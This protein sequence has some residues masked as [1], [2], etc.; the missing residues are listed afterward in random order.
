MTKL[1]G[2]VKLDETFC[3]ESRAYGSTQLEPV[4][5]HMARADIGAGLCT[6]PR[7]CMAN[8]ST[9]PLL[10]Y[11]P[12]GGLGNVL[13]GLASSTLLATV[14]CRRLGIAWGHNT[15]VQALGSF[16]EL[17]QVPAG[18]EFLNETEGKA[19]IVALDGGKVTSNCTAHMGKTW[20]EGGSR[21]ASLMHPREFTFAGPGGERISAWQCPVL[22]VRSNM[23]FAPALLKNVA[24]NPAAQWLRTHGLACT[25]T[26]TAVSA[27][28][29]HEPSHQR[30]KHDT[31]NA[32]VVPYFGE[33]SYHL[34]V[35]RIKRIEL[36]DESMSSTTN[37]AVVGVHVRMVILLAYTVKRLNATLQS[38]PAAVSVPSPEHILRDFGFLDCIAKVRAQIKAD[39][40]QAAPSRVYLAADNHAV[41]VEANATLGV[42]VLLPPPRH[43]MLGAERRG[44]MVT[45]RGSLATQGALDELLILARTNA[46]VVWDLKDSTY[47]AVAS[48]WAA[49]RAAGQ[50]R[51]GGRTSRPWWGVYLVA[52]GCQRVPDAEVEPRMAPL[53]DK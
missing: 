44:K 42:N 39:G 8:A 28:S 19:Q 47:S 37:I 24:A 11:H 45:R 29:A 27:G 7:T 16:A 50:S 21:L 4:L 40:E 3:A 13:F 9:A 33:L 26:M 49:H 53:F 5:A 17:F 32:K 43:I 38:I 6:R 46:M 12:Q 52:H 23:Y 22:H 15:N 36:A 18:V 1:C 31:G 2:L 51:G 30:P 41:R 48:S 35:P 14:L 34:L 25:R 20:T 10:V